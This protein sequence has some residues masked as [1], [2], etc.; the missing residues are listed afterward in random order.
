L[1]AA[2][3]GATGYVG[4]FVVDRLVEEGVSVRAWRRPKSDIR[5]LPSAVE[6]MDGGLDRPDSAAALVQGADMLVHCALDHAPGRYRGGEGDDLARFL[7]L[8]VGESLALLAAAREAGVRRCVVLSSRAVFGGSTGGGPISDDAPGRPDTHYGAAK[9]ALEAFVRAWGV[10]D[11]WAIAA[12]RPTGVYGMVVPAERSKWFDLVRRLMRG[13][14]APVRAGTEVHGRDVADAVWRVLRAAP[15]QVAGRMFNCSDIVVSTR[16]IA[17][18]VHRAAGA[19]G[20]MPEQAPAPANVMD[21]AGLKALG[22]QFG[23]WPL[24]EETVG[25]L[26]ESVRA[27][28]EAAQSGPTSPASASFASSSAGFP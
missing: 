18:L 26:V 27:A 6:W 2:V 23:G 12:L 13:E 19:S 9:A 3:T 14:A 8:N 22:V 20:P 24:F 5:G 17:R 21:C 15:G 7:R 1:T 10:R 4:R 16:D 28:A 11:G 25:R